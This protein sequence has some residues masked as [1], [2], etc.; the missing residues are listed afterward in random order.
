[1]IEP[2]WIDH[3]DTWSE[4]S[5]A[6]QNIFFTA[7]TH[8]GEERVRVMSRRPFK[9]VKEMDWEMRFRWNSVTNNNSLIY[10]L[11]DFGDIEIATNLNGK[12]VLIPGNYDTNEHLRRFNEPLS[13]WKEIGKTK[14][15]KPINAFMTHKPE[16]GKG[17]PKF[18]L[19]GHIHHLQLVKLNGLNV[20]VDCHNFYPVPI[21][22]VLFRYKAI[23]EHYD[24]NVFSL[25]CGNDIKKIQDEI[26]KRKRELLAGF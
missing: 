25:E 19:Y 2:E 8:F 24:Y 18:N 11:G 12:I 14:D 13:R 20:G 3:A 16:D 6:G 17:Y 5:T 26:E 22:E 15:G 10:H 4:Y 9:S 21:E 1:M 7:D 23:Q